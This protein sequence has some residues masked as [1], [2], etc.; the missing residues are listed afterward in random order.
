MIGQEFPNR[1]IIKAASKAPFLEREEENKLAIKWVEEKDQQALHKLT[2]SHMRLVIAIAHKLKN[3]GLPLS[4][5]IQEGHIGLMEAAFRFDP[6]K[7]VRFSTYATWWIRA[8][9]QDYILRNWSI[10]RGGTSSGQKAL[11]FKLRKL[12]A[13]ITKSGVAKN[14]QELLSH[15]SSALGV[16]VKDVESMDAR[17]SG[18]ISLNVPVSDEANSIAE[19][20]DFLVSTEVLPDENVSTLIDG[21][22][23][24]NLL[25]QSLSILDKRE[26][27]IVKMRKLTDKK[28]TLDIL[29]AKL[30]VSKER[31]R[32]IETKA[33]EKLK[34]ELLKKD[35]SISNFSAL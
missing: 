8:S 14:Q 13:Q 27:Y 32:Q 5:M 4:D 25:Y 31:I 7:E 17:F 35:P 23:R 29:G 9:I 20:Q 16:S 18:D 19:R 30:G 12:K 10:V 15:L 26:Q 21:Q 34:Y 28:V 22:K 11:F 2:Q 3:Y 1:I 24:K 33:L 6:A